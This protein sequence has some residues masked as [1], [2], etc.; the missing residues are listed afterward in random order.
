MPDSRHHRGPHPEDAD[1]FAADQ[2]SASAAKQP[3]ISPGCFS[4]GYV[5]SLWP[6]IAGR[7]PLSTL[8]HGSG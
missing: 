3:T 7:K 2:W 1:L 8:R 6:L 5:E 4:R